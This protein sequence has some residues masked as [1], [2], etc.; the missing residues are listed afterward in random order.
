MFALK[1]KHRAYLF[2]PHNN[3]TIQLFAK[4]FPAANSLNSRNS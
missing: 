4:S 2:Y 1:V 3:Q